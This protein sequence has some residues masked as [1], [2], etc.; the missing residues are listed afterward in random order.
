MLKRSWFGIA[1]LLTL[2]AFGE[3]PQ[4]D[5]ANAAWKLGKEAAITGKILRVEVPEEAKKGMH[6]ASLPVDLTPFRGKQ[7]TMAIRARAVK[8][9]QPSRNY[10]GVKFMLHYRAGGGEF[11]CHPS[12]L[13]GSF[14]W[15]ELFFNVRVPEDAGQGTFQF[16]LQDSSGLVEFDL[17]SFR[18][19]ELFPMVNREFRVKYPPRLANDP[20]RRGVMSPARRM[21]E[22][23][24]QT[25]R[26]WKVN[27]LRFQFVRNWGKAGTDQDL[28]EYDRWIEQRC[29]DLDLALA[30]AEKYGVKVVIDLHSP[31]GGRDASRNMNMFYDRKFADHFIAVWKKLAARYKGNPAVWGYD[32]INEPV[33]DRPALVD[34]W[35]IQRLAAE[36]VRTIDPDTPIIIE[37]NQWDSPDAFG[38]LSP[39]AMDNVIYQVHMYVPGQFTHQ[40]VG[41]TDGERGDAAGIRYP[42]TIGKVHW[43]RDRLKKALA[44]V[45]DFQKRH[46]AR[47]FVGE[48]SAITWAPGASDY[49]RDCIDI[50]EEY[51]WDWTYHAYREWQ[52][53]S[54]EHEGENQKSFR[55]SADNPRKQ[56]LLKGF[57]K[58]Q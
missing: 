6:A 30:W 38:Y 35:N 15:R 11:W 3:I 1:A 17:A 9:S 25:L 45:L 29:T 16:G 20:Q 55:P 49:L 39:L 4:P 41:N 2:T 48:F 19:F 5:L 7:V 50:F 37:S 56:V 32:L 52:G 31:P 33:Q 26:D 46:N 23:D 13:H 14:D 28:A 54:V 24:F 22:E 53:W 43:D 8:V 27:L 51:G 40:G 57:S 18:C 42:G 10:F 12:G 58:N 44:P 36:A 34:Y 21:T 47:I